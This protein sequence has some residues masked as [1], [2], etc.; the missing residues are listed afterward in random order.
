MNINDYRRAMDRLTPD[1]DLK[2]KI[3]NS[4][5]QKQYIPAR[6]IVTGLFAAALT[7][8]CLFTVALAA[9]PEL[10]TAVLS[11][12]RME[13]REQ[14]P[15]G[16]FS[17]SQPGPGIRQTDIGQLV[18]AQY[19]K[20]DSYRYGYSGGL[21]HHLTWSEDWKTLLDA[22]FWAIKDSKLVP[23]EVDMQTSQIDITFQDIHYQGE[24]WWFI[25]DGQLDYF[26]G[27]NRTIDEDGEHE[28]DW[29]FSPVP[30]RTD[31][32]RLRLSTGR[33]M[34][35]VE[36]PF[37]YYLDTGEIEDL[38]AGVDPA[39]LE[40]SDGAI[41]SDNFQLAL[42]TGHASAQFPNGWEWLY[43][44]ETG[45]LTDVRSLG[46]VGAEQAAFADDGTL[47][48]YDMTDDVDGGV[49]YVTAYSY[50]ISS[51]HTVQTLAQTPYYRSWDENPSGVE[52]FGSHCVLIEPGGQVRAV[53]LKTGSHTLL[54]GFTFH[55]EDSLRF[56]P[57]GTKL[58]YFAMDPEVEGLG[59]SQIGVADLEKGVFFAFDREGYENL[60]EGG[61]GWDDDNT[62]SIRAHTRD[63][64]T[65]Y[66]LLY[67]F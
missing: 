56:N 43:D 58:L 67:Q 41:W 18:K 11:F 35:Y 44:R 60:Y 54:E 46:G 8:A 1:P 65:E 13:E 24:F 4:T 29:N 14:V 26:T 28:C 50:D 19:I 27:D 40:E 37:L 6:R 49:Q 7:L 62:M 12:F 9:S 32:L 23:V 3:M 42:I 47:I 59:I 33:Q 63:S 53:D 25:H 57:S 20:L 61:I 52:I 36:H 39:V 15:D 17:S 10:R 2:E 5:K 34:E 55:P 22:K 21:L 51:G 38:L 30:G 31:V 16:G 64:E 45:T 48:L 66:I